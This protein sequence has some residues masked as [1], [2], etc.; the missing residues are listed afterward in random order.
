MYLKIGSVLRQFNEV[1]TPM[2]SYK[3][4]YDSRRR[5]AY[6]EEQ[7]QIQGRIVLQTNATQ[8]RMT[9]A[10]Q[11]LES[12]WNQPNPSLLFVEDNGV[13]PSYLRLNASDCF[14]GPNVVDKSFPGD[15]ADV[16]A[17]GMLWAVTVVAKRLPTGVG[18]PLM[19]FTESVAMLSGGT[20]I[21]FVGGA[22]NLPERQIFKQNEP[23][24]YEQ[25][26][27]AVGLFGYP[28]PPPPLWPGAQLERMKPVL[29]SPRVTGLV[30]SEFEIQWTYR[31]GNEFALAGLPHTF[32]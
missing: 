7:W 8:T 19:E 15:A 27:R 23:F 11:Q 25:T 9:Q 30:D 2:I 29:I 12:D 26:G 20:I 22:I 17:T 21:G 28:S 10:L 24:I 1:K 14:D 6:I 3:P 13:T 18:S 4:F 32:A 16:Y 5:I 31:F